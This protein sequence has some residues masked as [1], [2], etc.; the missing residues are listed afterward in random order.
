MPKKTSIQ[1]AVEEV[2]AAEAIQPGTIVQL[3]SGGP[4]MTVKGQDT[5]T[6]DVWCLWFAG[7][8]LETGCFGVD[9]LTPINTPKKKE[10]AK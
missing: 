1:P 6:A 9:T 3:K 7:K 10:T 4:K 8:R 5:P 2:P